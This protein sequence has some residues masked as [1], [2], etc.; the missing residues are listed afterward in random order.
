[1]FFS[2]SP[3]ASGVGGGVANGL[4]SLFGGSL[5]GKKVAFEG[6]V[7]PAVDGNLAG[8]KTAVEAAGGT[9]GQ[10]VR[11]PITFSSWSSQAANVVGSKA[12]AVVVNNT[13]PNTATVAK[14]LLVAGFTGPIISTEGAN[15]DGLL[16]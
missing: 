3:L 16:K 11:D 13:D 9:M 4:K 1:Y 10:V 5:S 2:T 12:D 6:L 8:T 7:S 14:A 15:S